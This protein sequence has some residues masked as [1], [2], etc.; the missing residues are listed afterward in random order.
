[1]PKA[2]CW[3]VPPAFN[4]PVALSELPPTIDIFSTMITFFPALFASNAAVNPA[5][6]EPITTTSVVIFKSSS[7]SGDSSTIGASSTSGTSS[8]TGSSLVHPIANVAIKAIINNND[9]NFFVFFIC[10]SPLILVFFNSNY[11]NTINY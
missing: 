6:P 5:P 3:G 4:P 9:T 11:Y 1:M 10:T 7:T 8:I 2:A